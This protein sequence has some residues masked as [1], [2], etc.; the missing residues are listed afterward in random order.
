MSPRGWRGTAGKSGRA[1]SGEPSEGSGRSL[2]VVHQRAGGVP[3]SPGSHWDFWLIF[4]SRAGDQALL[5]DMLFLPIDIRE[6][7]V[8]GGLL[9]CCLRA[10]QILEL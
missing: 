8:G 2:L 3:L 5:R 9:G 6:H 7:M 1:G 10:L 4:L